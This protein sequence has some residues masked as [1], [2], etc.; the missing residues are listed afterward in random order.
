VQHALRSLLL[1]A[2]AGSISLQSLTLRGTKASVDLLQQLQ[3]LPPTA[4][5][6]EIDLDCSDSL[7]AIAALSHLQHLQ[8]EG[9]PLSGWRYFNAAAA[10]D[11]LA[12]LAAGLQQLTE[13]HINPVK[14]AQ[15]LQ[16]PPK[17]QQLHITLQSYSLQELQQLAAWLPSHASILSSLH[18]TDWPCSQS[19]DNER[20]DALSTLTAA[21][22]AA[23]AAAALPAK[24]RAG[25]Q[26]ASLSV[27]GLTDNATLDDTASAAP[28]LQTLPA[29]SL[30]YLA[31]KFGWTKTADMDALCS[32]TGLRHLRLME[33]FPY[34]GLDK[35]LVPLSAL[36]QLTRL[37]LSAVRGT[38]LQHL[39]LPRL[40]HLV[41]KHL[42]YLGPAV[43]QRL[44]HLSSLV[45][46]DVRACFGLSCTDTLPANLRTLK[47]WAKPVSSYRPRQPCNFSFAP[48]LALSKL[49]QL[50][51]DLARVACTMQVARAV[52]QLSTLRS[53]QELRILWDDT[54]GR[55]QA[56]WPRGWGLG[57][58]RAAAAVEDFAAALQKLPL[59]AL[60]WRHAG[61]PAAVL[62]QLGN[63][64]GLTALTLHSADDSECNTGEQEVAQ[65]AALVRRLTA[66]Q[67]LH[68]RR[69]TAAGGDGQGGEALDDSSAIRELMQAIC[70]LQQ[71]V[72]V[73]VWL[74]VRLPDAAV[75]QLNDSLPQLLS[76]PVAQSCTASVRYA[77]E[78]TPV[79]HV[80]IITIDACR[81]M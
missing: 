2:D 71:L 33:R 31:C 48:L 61:L 15:L 3:A 7:Q 44:G 37:E 60:S 10:D 32:L 21:F 75:A 62:Q 66:L 56:R 13:L 19:S 49:E 38:Q 57:L 25:W 80:S 34:G 35:A 58:G 74:R 54:A 63:L 78:R 30:T 29:G 22:A 52:A 65:L 77:N 43:P 41:L 26:L 17:L 12:P 76:G 39:Q 28:L 42:V 51:L 45:V 59:K 46:L 36:Q 5:R 53:L 50:Q 8:L 40:Q 79:L 73:R 81:W 72:A 69:D 68:L 24:A 11:A 64:Q 67:C 70:S 55:Q 27:L 20:A 47:L 6:A 1:T 23:A 16:L 4:L 18:L 9:L 14:P